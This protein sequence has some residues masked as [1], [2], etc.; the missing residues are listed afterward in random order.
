MFLWYTQG[1]N[2][3]ESTGAKLDRFS[4]NNKLYIMYD[5]SGETSFWVGSV[6]E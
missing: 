1:N 6:K 4:A 3:G 2:E 5:I